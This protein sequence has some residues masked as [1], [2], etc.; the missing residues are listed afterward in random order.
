MKTAAAHTPSRSSSAASRRQCGRTFT[1]SSRKTGAP[2]ASLDGGPGLAPDP[3]HHRPAAADQ[4]RLLRL[5]LA[6][7]LGLDRAVRPRPRLDRLHQHGDRVRHLVA[8]QLQGAL[9]HELGDRGARATGRSS[10]RAGTRP[11]PRAAAPAGRRAARRRRRRC[12]ALIGCTAC[13]LAERGRL[14]Q[15]RHDLRS[16]PRPSILLTAMTHGGAPGRE[17]ARGDVAVAGPDRRARVEHE[18]RGVGVGQRLVH[19][20]LHALGQPVEGL[21]EPGQV[22]HDEL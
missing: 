3:L 1:E 19:R 8:G 2:T 11:A 15:R 16:A 9:A 4:D 13:G 18:Q 22:D 7:Q 5:G 14:G 10:C 12:G 21:L 17:H 20:A 6:D